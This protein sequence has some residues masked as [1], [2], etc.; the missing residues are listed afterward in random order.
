MFPNSNPEV[1]EILFRV[2]MCFVWQP[3]I[4]SAITLRARKFTNNNMN[5][6]LK[7]YLGQEAFLTG[8]RQIHFHLQWWLFGNDEDNSHDLILL[9]SFVLHL[10]RDSFWQRQH[11]VNNKY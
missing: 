1:S 3:V 10:I 5:E 11:T 4:I 9:M 6:I 8:S 7:H 2:R